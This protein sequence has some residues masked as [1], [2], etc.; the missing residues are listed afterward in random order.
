MNRCHVKL[1]PVSC[2]RI[3]ACLVYGRDVPGTCSVPSAADRNLTA[4]P[5]R[6]AQGPPPADHHAVQPQPSGHGREFGCQLDGGAGRSVRFGMRRPDQQPACGPVRL[7]V[8]P[9]ARP[10]PQQE[11]QDVVAVASAWPPACRSRSGS[12]SRTALPAR[13]RSKTRE[14][15]GLS[16]ARP[17]ARRGSAA[18]R[19]PVDLSGPSR[20]PSTRSRLPS[21]SSA[22]TA[23][24]RPCRDRK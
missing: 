5:G 20:P 7:Q 12:G 14:S 24:P 22:R 10:V 4:A 21:A 16:S 13:C 8:H 9:G 17:V 19:M 23:P 6:Q 11:R 15:K 3:L 18:S 2:C 1:L